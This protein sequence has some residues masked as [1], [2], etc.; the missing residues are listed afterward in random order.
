MGE[1]VA[2]LR[3]TVAYDGTDFCGFQVQATGRTV[4]GELEAAL[5]QIVWLE[6][7]SPD[8]AAQLTSTYWAGRLH[9]FPHI[10]SVVAGILI[11]MLY[12]A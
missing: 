5:A 6:T 2:Y 4:Q 10:C 3:A 7:G 12:A 11:P 9:E 8:L 1:T